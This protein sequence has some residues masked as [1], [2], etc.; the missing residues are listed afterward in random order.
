MSNYENRSLKTNSL[1]MEGASVRSGCDQST[2]NCR[3]YQQL[4]FPSHS[5]GNCQVQDHGASRF[6]VR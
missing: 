1:K 3:A 5:S 4:A 2:G 6:S